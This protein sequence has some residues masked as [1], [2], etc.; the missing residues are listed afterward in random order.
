MVAQVQGVYAE[1]LYRH[2]NG[3]GQ[4]RRPMGSRHGE[5]NVESVRLMDTEKS[6]NPTT[7]PLAS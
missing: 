4:E 1:H 2:N 5:G 6:V 7:N 3:L